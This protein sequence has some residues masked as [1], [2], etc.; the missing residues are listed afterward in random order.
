[1]YWIGS[2]RL[3]GMTKRGS[4]F[5]ALLAASQNFFHPSAA[6]RCGTIDS[7]KRATVASL[8]KLS[9]TNLRRSAT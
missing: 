4:F 8:P 5:I 7:S 9:T 6:K 1:M 3:P 2:C